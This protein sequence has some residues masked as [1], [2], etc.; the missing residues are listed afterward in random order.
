MIAIALKVGELFA[1]LNLDTSGFNTSIISA[2]NLATSEGKAISAILG[3]V[4]LGKELVG[5]A[6][7]FE[8]A[9]AGVKKTVDET[10][11]TSYEDLEKQIRKLSTELPATAEEIARVYELS[12]QLGIGADDLENF[13]RVMINLGETTNLSSEEAATSLARFANIIGTSSD[14]YSNLGSTIV[15]LGNNFATTES[16][17]VGMAMRIAG[18]G[19]QIGLSESDVLGFAAAFSSVGINVEAGGSAFSSVI[20]KM[21]LAASEGEEGLAGFANV[22]GMT[23]ASFKE[24]FEKDAAG[25]V[26]AFVKGLGKADDAIGILQ[27]LEIT[28]IRQRQ[29]MLGAAEAS[30]LFAEAINMSSNA[31]SE[32]NALSEEAA[33]RYETTASKM[34]VLKNKT[35]DLGLGF[36]KIGKDITDAGLDVALNTMDKIAET[37]VT[38]AEGLAESAKSTAQRYLSFI[39]KDIG[40]LETIVPMMFTPKMDESTSIVLRQLLIENG[41]INEAGEIIDVPVIA[42]PI[43]AESATPPTDNLS[44]IVSEAVK[45]T[46]A[47]IEVPVEVSSVQAAT[48]GNG[49]KTELGNAGTQAGQLFNSSLGSALANTS[50]VSAALSQITTS[51]RNQALALSASGTQGGKMFSSGLAAGIRAG[52]SSI[53]SAAREVAQAAVTAANAALKIQSPSRVMMKSGGYFDEGFAKGILKEVATVRNASAYMAN[54]AVNAASVRNPAGR[55]GGTGNALAQIAGGNTGS[56]MP[57]IRLTTYLNGREVSEAMSDDT[58]YTQNDRSGRIAARYGTVAT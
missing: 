8:T 41:Y 25:A 52:K 1:T 24:T 53:T 10:A 17:I 20:A 6:I 45:N 18:A 16:E 15:D 22:A 42:N 28:E 3:G 13:S 32:N 39:E 31:Y 56:N 7:D 55:W 36:G 33:K 49:A 29:A 51:V 21:A 43:P 48:L 47:E 37:P 2:T 38:V 35:A 54:M 46:P 9:F 40:N 23:A 11:L 12:G 34:E 57:P 58:A 50:G 5:S 44:G 30:D 26:L 19:K 4:K 27:D 14:E